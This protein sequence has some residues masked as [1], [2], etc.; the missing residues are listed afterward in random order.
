MK[1]KAFLIP[2]VLLSLS[3]SLNAQ[4]WTYTDCV[5]YAREHNISLQKSRLSQE[6]AEYNLKESEGLWQP[7]LDFATSHSYTNSPWGN[8]N[9]NSYSGN[10]GL[11]AQWTLWNCAVREN[12]N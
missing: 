4:T 9:R 7:T 6:T 2:T 3:M 10:Y 1:L 12:N 11:N 5:E 8:G